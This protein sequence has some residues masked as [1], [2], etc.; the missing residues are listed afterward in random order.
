MFKFAII[1]P[2]A[3]RHFILLFQHPLSGRLLGVQKEAREPR[4]LTATQRLFF[5][6]CFVV[7]MS[8]AMAC[9]YCIGPAPLFLKVFAVTVSLGLSLS[10]IHDKLHFGDASWFWLQKLEAKN[11]LFLECFQHSH[12]CE[13]SVKAVTLFASANGSWIFQDVTNHHGIF[14]DCSPV[15]DAVY[16]AVLCFPFQ[17]MKL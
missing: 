15:N 1:L 6:Y 14:L 10:Q 5:P 2:N 13:V 9:F 11:I 4:S 7:A 17:L 12:L 3:T 8:I 16:V